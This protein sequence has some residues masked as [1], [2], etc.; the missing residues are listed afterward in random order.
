ML[1]ISGHPFLCGSLS[2]L[3]VL[4]L[5][6]DAPRDNP[7]DP[8]NPE[9]RYGTIKGS[10]QTFCLPHR[11]V[12]GV[13]VTWG[14]DSRMVHADANGQFV[15][16]DILPNNGILYLHANGYRADS[17]NVQWNKNRSPEIEC[18]LNQ[19]PQ[20]QQTAVFSSV[21]NRY[22]NLRTYQMTVQAWIQDPDLDIEKVNI[23]APTLGLHRTLTYNPS[24]KLFQDSF[25]PVDLS[26]SSLQSVVGKTISISVTDLFGF[27]YEVGQVS[28][29]RIIMDEVS[30]VQPSSYQITG[31]RPKLQWKK[32]QPGFAFTYILEVYTDEVVPV[33]V[34]EKKNLAG[35]LTEYDLD[36]D[37]PTGDYFWV[38]WC[39]DEFGNRS[40]SKPASFAVP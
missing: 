11:P 32:F 33:R 19:I 2:V 3:V 5:A 39:V 20:L 24:D 25:S 28:L 29:K 26:L 7:L 37:L 12:P 23:D 27:S 15:I 17:V 18:F 14:P 21:L 38:I 16:S 9:Y 8:Q 36:K 1:R 4:G 31:N 35:D 34:W 13:Q 6:C 10:V 22:P 30:Y 40:R